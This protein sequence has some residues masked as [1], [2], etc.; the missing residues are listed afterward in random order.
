ME[1]IDYIAI[2]GALA[3]TPHLF[4]LIKKH[5]TKPEIRLI[6]S[7]Y[8]EIGFTS[9]GDIFNIRLAF[10][11]KHHDIVISNLKIRLVHQSG[12]VKTFTWQGMRQE[13]STMTTPDG[14][15]MPQ[16]KAHSVLAIKLNQQNIEERSIQ[17]QEVNFM[18]N[19]VDIDS[20]AIKKMNYLKEQNTFIHSQFLDSQEMTDLYNYIKQ[21]FSWKVGKYT[22]HIDIESP[23]EFILQNNKIEFT[24][25][26]I[27]IEFL[28]KNKN[29][30][31]ASFE[32]LKEDKSN[33]VIWNWRNP[34]L[35]N[36]ENN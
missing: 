26:S 28:E 6:T 30:I 2:L 18:T 14:G 32:E 23:E 3:W 4:S 20:N 36:I 12:E 5:F 8:G 11:V 15:V 35:N 9:L 1:F 21:S 33:A 17:C 29:Q 10:S 31:R 22:A 13:L 34:Q 16:E 7:K 25:N 24:L 27:D 19:K